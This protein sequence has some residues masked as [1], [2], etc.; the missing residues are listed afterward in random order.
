MFLFGHIGITLGAAVLAT[1]L[2]TGRRQSLSRHQ[3]TPRPESL[4]GEPQLIM[5]GPGYI[6]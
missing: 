1:G 6:D 3:D 5:I 4:S 2:I